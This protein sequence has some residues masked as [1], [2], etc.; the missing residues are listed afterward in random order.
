MAYSRALP[1]ALLF[2]SMGDPAMS[3]IR[4][5]AAQILSEIPPY[6]R[7]LRS[8]DLPRPNLYNKMTGGLK[9]ETMTDSWSKGKNL[10]GCN[11][12]VGWYGSRLGSAAYLGGFPL[13]EMLSSIGMERAWIDS[14]P[15]NRPQYG[16][17]LRHTAFHVD[18][19]L[20]FDGDVLYRAAAG[21]GGKAAG[22]D[23]LCRVRGN[24]A[25]DWRSLQ[26]WIDLD[27]YFGD[28]FVSPPW[29][30]GWWKV[31]WQGDVYYYY[32]DEGR[33]AFWTQSRVTAGSPPPTSANDSGSVEFDNG[34]NITIVWNA[35][36]TKEK[37]GRAASWEPKR[38]TK[39][40]MKGTCNGAAGLTAV[41]L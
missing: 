24:G 28:T 30:V 26:G 2:H 4:D 19:A 29:L 35:T 1:A 31:A 27:L 17:I 38:G 11:A 3:E 14:T 13:K 36:G 40:S 18:V 23:V 10:T 8:D 25:Y 15:D 6:P 5:R 7:Q 32:F 34:Y 12:F 39:P 20:D 33:Q 21:Q 41:K 22:A 37:L 16:D 9:H